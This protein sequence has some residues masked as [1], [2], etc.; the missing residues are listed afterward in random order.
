MEAM[1][2][3]EVVQTSEP[4]KDTYKIAYI[5]HFFLGAGNL[6]PWNTFITAID[7]FAY[8]YP[9]KHVE[10][11]FSVAYMTSSLIVLLLMIK[12]Q[13]STMR[14]KVSFRLKM[15]FGFSMFVL[16]L[17]VTPTIDWAKGSSSWKSDGSFLATVAS[18][19][20][21]GLADGLIGGSLIG[22]AGKLPKEYM[23]AVFAGTASSGVLVSVL[24]VITKAS[25]PENPRGLQTSAH[26][27][28]IVSAI[29]VVV[30]TICSNL[31]FRLPVMQQHCNKQLSQQHNH[32]PTTY[33]PK[34]SDIAKKILHPAIGILSIYVVTLSIFPGFISDDNHKSELLKDWYPILVIM[35]YNFS[36]L[37]GK[38]LTALLIP[39]NI[40]RV[41][42]ACLAR[43]VFYPA[44]RANLHGPRWL[45]S[46]V[47]TV[48]L[49]FLL[50]ISNGYLTSTL[51]I[52][53]P[54]SVSSL[55]AETAAVVMAM[56]LGV[57][58]VVGSILGWLWII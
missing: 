9:T 51:M 30:C 15:N 45:K 44:F 32:D 35:V 58:L 21:C 22:S 49:T 42:W 34:L 24:R 10:R 53:T 4:V 52:L 2:I 40:T 3:A 56:A 31:L 38:T 11:V 54:K 55:E 29:I 23:Q 37:A 13:G 46:E 16:S 43:V 47:F 5:L 6:L 39:S 57:G 27:Y 50:G 33:R 48:L 36:D 12:G 41:T 26:F 8:L 20:V 17:M 1:K 25:L 28:F 7:Y 19:V 14:S 18:V